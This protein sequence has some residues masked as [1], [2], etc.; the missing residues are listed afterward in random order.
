MKT[1]QHQLLKQADTILKP[2]FTPDLIFVF[3]SRNQFEGDVLKQLKSTFPESVFFGCTTS[4][5]IANDGVHDESIVYTC[6]KFE[7]PN[8]RFKLVSTPIIKSANSFEAGKALSQKLKDTNL[9]HILVLS[10]GQQVN[11]TDLVKGISNNLPEEISVTGGLAGDGSRFEKTYV[12]DENGK[13]QTGI[14]SAIGLCG[15]HFKIGFA[16]LGG[17]SPFGIE[18]KVTKSSGNVLYEI[19]GSPALE[20]Y[21]Y[22]LGENAQNLPM[23]ALLFPINMRLDDDTEP[24]VRTILNVNEN[25]QSLIFAGDIPNNSYVQLMKS[26]SYKLIDAAE[27]AGNIVFNSMDEKPDLALFVSCVGR[28]LVM[29]QLVDEEVECASDSLKNPTVTGFY[30]YGEIAPFKSGSKCELHNQTM[31][32]TAIKE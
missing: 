10:D 4:G 22:Y 8:S 6:I 29:K 15:D 31:T 1:F 28:K 24:V 26:N 17:W 18:R 12:L 30:S 27:E 19:D 14:I 2:D 23:S 3:G 25:D 20:L 11:G 21:K 16:S 32:I 9:K 13:P 5:E 7:N